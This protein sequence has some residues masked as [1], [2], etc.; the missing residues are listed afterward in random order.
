MLLASWPRL[1]FPAHKQKLN[2]R[3]SSVERREP[4]RGRPPERTR[5][6]VMLAPLSPSTR[7]GDYMDAQSQFPRRRKR[8]GNTE[9]CLNQVQHLSV[10]KHQMQLELG[11]PSLSCHPSQGD[12]A[13]ILIWTSLRRAGRDEARPSEQLPGTC[14]S[15]HERCVLEA[16]VRT[17]KGTAPA[18]WAPP[19]APPHLHQPSPGWGGVHTSGKPLRR[20]CGWLP[21]LR[22]PALS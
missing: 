15:C 10:K 12:S 3:K 20:V 14:V 1:P 18:L 16:L 2:T 5:T 9:V 11:F 8:K 19:A 22:W 17:A 13:D 4:G 21:P 7:R 6:L